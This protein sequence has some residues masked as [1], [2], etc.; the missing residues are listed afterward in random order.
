MVFKRGIIAWPLC[1]A[2]PRLF[3]FPLRASARPICSYIARRRAQQIPVILMGGRRA[4]RAGHRL[5]IFS[6]VRAPP[7]RLPR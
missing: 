1:R 7:P 5:D 4:R 2:C 6:A 3:F